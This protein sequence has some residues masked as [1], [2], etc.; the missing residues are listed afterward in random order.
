MVLRVRVG[1]RPFPPDIKEC[2]TLLNAIH[3]KI[4]N[5]CQSDLKLDDARPTAQGEKEKKKSPTSA[6]CA[7]TERIGPK[8]TSA[9]A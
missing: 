9:G 5:A 8:G 2:G 3:N 1:Q 7:V 4:I 6:K